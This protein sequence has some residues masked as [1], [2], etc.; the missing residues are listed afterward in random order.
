MHLYIFF[1]TGI[2]GQLDIHG[3]PRNVIWSRLNA[4]VLPGASNISLVEPVDWQIGEEIVITTTSY[5]L[6]QT[7]IR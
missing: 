2:F 4:T 1:S 7:E 6:E 3:M 5:S